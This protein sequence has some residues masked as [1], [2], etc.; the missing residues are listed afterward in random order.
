MCGIACPRMIFR[1][2]FLACS[3]YLHE[4]CFG[5]IELCF[6][7][8]DLPFFAYYYFVCRNFFQV[9]GIH[10]DVEIHRKRQEN[11][12]SYVFEEVNR[13]FAHFFLLLQI[14]KH[15]IIVSIRAN[16]FVIALLTAHK[17]VRKSVSRTSR[18]LRV[19]ILYR[20]WLSCCLVRVIRCL[21]NWRHTFSVAFCVCRK[22]GW[23]CF[24][25]RS[26]SAEV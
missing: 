9:F 25:R 8:L 17:C 14:H 23:F 22:Y 7:I 1:T 15:R 10:T 6:E 2:A 5:F 12:A 16:P 18:I 20:I 13:D 11:P 24:L 19:K 21:E 3:K 26:T 4:S